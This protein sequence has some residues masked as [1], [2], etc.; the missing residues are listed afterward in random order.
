M[1]VRVSDI[2]IKN[3]VPK[4]EIN[5]SVTNVIIEI[6]SKRLGATAVL[7]KGKIQGIITDG[8]IRRMLEK[9]PDF[10]NLKAKDIL[11]GNPRTIGKDELVV[12][13]L[14]TMRENNITQLLVVDNN[15]YVGVIHLH[16]ILN[17]GI[18]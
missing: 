9:S 5:E 3:E 12:N 8:D 1:F 7:D 2:S 10:N 15:V 17:E 4:V 13:A 18:F 16:D 6:S 11:S 14:S